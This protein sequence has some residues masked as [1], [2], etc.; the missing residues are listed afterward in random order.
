LADFGA[1]VG[2]DVLRFWQIAMRNI[3]LE[4]TQANRRVLGGSEGAAKRSFTISP[5]NG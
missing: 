4:K 5:W 3:H 1:E 2:D